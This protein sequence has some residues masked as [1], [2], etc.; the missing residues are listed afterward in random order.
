MGLEDL[1]CLGMLAYSKETIY[2]APD[3]DPFGVRIVSCPK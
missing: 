3:F 2:G 1:L